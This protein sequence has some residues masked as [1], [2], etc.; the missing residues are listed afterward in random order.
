MENTLLLVRLDFIEILFS[1]VF[2]MFFC[3]FLIGGLDN[4]VV[5][6]KRNG[7]GLL[8]YT[9][10]APVQIVSFSPNSL[11]LLSCAEVSLFLFII[12]INI[13]KIYCSFILS[14]LL[15]N[16]KTDFGIWSLDQKQVVKEKTE[17]RATAACWSLNGENFAIG[18]E[19]GDVSVRVHTGDE[20]LRFRR[21]DSIQCLQ[22]LSSEA[23]RLP[24]SNEQFIVVGSWDKTI[25]LYQ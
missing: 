23:F 10:S 13:I 20:T 19:N 1:S 25:S 16:L 21:T 2:Y 18:F 12:T 14:I 8:K 6:W 3:F 11:R 22:F 5:I 17:S 15:S 9:H 7:E 4:V 24:S